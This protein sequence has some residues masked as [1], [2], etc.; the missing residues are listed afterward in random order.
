LSSFFASIFY[1][2]TSYHS[3]DFL[4][5]FTPQ[6]ALFL[7][8]DISAWALGSWIF[9]PAYKQLPISE[10]TI[11]NSLQGVFS[12]LFGLLIFKTEIFH[13]SRLIGALLVIGSVALINQEKGKWKYNTFTLLLI[14]GTVLFGLAT[15][16][17]N[18][19]I[20]RQYFSSVAF[21]MIFNFG[22]TAFAVL[23]LN[24]K[25]IK[26]LHAMYKDKKAF[27]IVVISSFISALTFFLVYNAYKLHIVASQ[28]NLILSS[29]T[30]LIVLLGSLFF[31]EKQHLKKKL[32]A[33]IIATIGVYFIS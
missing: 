31:N 4:S 24:P 19:I 18:V 6:V 7:V 25:T 2:F 16:V 17:D 32:I 21:L 9:Y 13:L 26:N 28:S 27:M 15:V 12:L 33:G 5:L 22:I 3:S 11:A 8:L 1:F 14:A 23:A 29:Q 20:A 30:V 10:I